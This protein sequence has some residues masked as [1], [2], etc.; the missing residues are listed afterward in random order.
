MAREKKKKTPLRQRFSDTVSLPVETLSSLCRM[1][2]MG[3]REI[4]L[5]GYQGIAEYDDTF[6]RVRV[7]GMQIVFWGCDLQV[8]S[9]D[10]DQL[11]ISGVMEKIEFLSQN[12]NSGRER[13]EKNG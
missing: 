7:K 11:I 9:M 1:E 4:T 13:V 6:L 2:I 12:S 8:V 5:E 3:N 10:D